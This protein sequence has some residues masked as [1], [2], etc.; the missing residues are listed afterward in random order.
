MTHSPLLLNS[1]IFTLSVDVGSS[2]RLSSAGSREGD[3]D[4]DK[5]GGK[6]DPEKPRANDP[7]AAKTEKLS[8]AERRDSDLVNSGNAFGS[9]SILG[10]GG[11]GFWNRNKPELHKRLMLL[12]TVSILWP[13]WFRFRHYFPS[14]Q[15]PEIWFA[16]IL[17]ESVTLLAWLWDYREHGRILP[18]LLFGGLFVIAEHTVETFAFDTGPWGIVDQALWSLFS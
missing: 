5:S 2:R 13:A 9:C 10:F 17:A 6:P 15:S 14:V 4:K 11:A 1:A 16:L 7:P 3:E 8:E 18:V 12:A